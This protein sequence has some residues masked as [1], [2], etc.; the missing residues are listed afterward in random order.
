MDMKE[1]IK[2]AL[3]GYGYWGNNLLRNMA[4]H[5][6]CNVVGMS[7]QNLARRQKAAGLYPHI[8]TF[9]NYQDMLDKAKPEA[10]VIAT[11][12]ANHADIAI[13][14]IASGAH[15]LVEKPLATSSEDCDIILEAARDAGKTVMVDHTF[16][17]YSPITYLADII[18][19]GELGTLLYYDS[20]RVNLGGFQPR[21]NVLWDLAPH[22]IAILDLFTNNA[23]P[24]KVVAIG[25]KHFGSTT[26]NLCYLNLKYKNDFNAHLNMNWSAPIKSRL[27]TLGGDKQM[28]VF[29]DN[30]PTE[31]IRI[32]DKSVHLKNSSPTDFMIN[33]RVG[34]MVAPVVLQ[35]EAL[36]EM[37][38][39]FTGSLFEGRTPL[40][41]GECGARGVRILE[42]AAR[43]LE[44]DGRPESVAPAKPKPAGRA[45]KKSA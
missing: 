32:Y 8:P 20:V 43:S 6:N 3:V 10:V 12:P 19:K 44:H 28:A 22:D 39:E 27:I 5:P 9:E 2:I 11:P 35:K 1:K 38:S 25:V 37:L 16:L 41:D 36:S 42:A 26:E 40:S 14:A 30:M 21:V 45:A 7:E 29:D 15:V 31:K 34:N 24:E 17:F 13:N 18:R 4:F 23:V 33:Y